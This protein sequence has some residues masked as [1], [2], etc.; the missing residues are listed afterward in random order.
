MDYVNKIHSD[1]EATCVKTNEPNSELCDILNPK[2]KYARWGKC[3]EV[4]NNDPGKLKVCVENFDAEGKC[5][6]PQD[7]NGPD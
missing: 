2:G 4:A 7:G 1:F 6:G 5:Y 3:V